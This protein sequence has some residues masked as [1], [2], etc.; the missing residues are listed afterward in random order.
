[1]RLSRSGRKAEPCSVSADTAGCSPFTTERIHIIHPADSEDIF[2]CDPAENKR[3][4]HRTI[5]TQNSLNPKTLI[6]IRE[7][8]RATMS[9]K[10]IA[11]NAGPRKGF[12]TDTLINEAIKGVLAE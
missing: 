11:F 6:D 1:M 8:R 2:A 7:K 9:K 5:I 12:N 4:I 3:Q 10:I